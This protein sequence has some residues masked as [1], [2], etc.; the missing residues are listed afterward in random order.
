MTLDE[1]ETIRLID[2]LGRT[3]EDCAKQMG[4][5]RT[6]VQSV[7]NAARKKVAESLVNGVRLTIEGGDYIL[8]S[9][10][11]ECC[12]KMC[13]RNICENRHCG[14]D[15]GSSCDSKKTKRCVVD[16]NQQNK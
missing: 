5:A 6:T 4:V 13:A 15:S 14:K 16:E 8:C 1:Y 9:Y 7:Y 2:L 12:G 3:Q 10:G 11:T